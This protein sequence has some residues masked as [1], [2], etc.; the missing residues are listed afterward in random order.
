MSETST[1]SE[2]SEQESNQDGPIDVNDAYTQENLFPIVEKGK[3][4]K[5]D[6]YTI[7]GC[8]LIIKPE[9]LIDKIVYY[10]DKKAQ[11]VEQVNDDEFRVKYGKGKTAIMDFAEIIKQL[12]HLDKDGA[13]RLV[14]ETILDH[15][16][17]AFNGK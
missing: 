16:W 15:R 4:N 11:V 2:Q 6:Q 9:D 8:P 13:E 7:E 17:A 5:D 10:G 1:S 3:I 12:T 14:I